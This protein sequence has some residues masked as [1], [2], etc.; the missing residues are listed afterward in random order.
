RR[1][2]VAAPD[3]SLPQALARGREPDGPRL[4]RRALARAAT[5]YR[6]G[7]PQGGGQRGDP[8][9]DCLGPL[10]CASLDRADLGD[11]VRGEAPVMDAAIGDLIRMGTD[12]KQGSRTWIFCESKCRIDRYEG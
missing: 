9:R 6:G 10:P 12:P 4:L 1:L 11:T 7:D 8:P 5:Q 3:R 2:P